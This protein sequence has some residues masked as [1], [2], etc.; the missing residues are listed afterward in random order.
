MIEYV[1]TIE[2]KLNMNIQHKDGTFGGV[3]GKGRLPFTNA[4]NL[5][6]GLIRTIVIIVIGILVLSYFGFNIRQIAESKT[7]RENFSYVQEKMIYVWDNFLETPATF[8]WERII[9]DLGWEPFQAALKYADKNSR[10]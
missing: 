9:I 7:S 6:S 4:R 3:A 10:P 1:H 2:Q 5:K 8:V